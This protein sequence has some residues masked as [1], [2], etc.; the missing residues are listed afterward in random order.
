MPSTFDFVPQRVISLVPSM[1]ESLFDL[2]IGDRLIAVTDYCTK[3]AE[4]VARLPKV[5][6]TKNPDISQ[7]IALQPDMVLMNNE[8]NRLEDQQALE[9]AGITTWVT[10]PHTVFEAL[11]LLWDIM[12]IFCC[13][14]NVDAGARN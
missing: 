11:N 1:T 10:G 4:K 2:D 3:P 9:A 13:P 12:D 8:E 5:G 14:T 7:I 6:G